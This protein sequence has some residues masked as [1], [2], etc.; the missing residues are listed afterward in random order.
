MQLRRTALGTVI[1]AGLILSLSSCG[2]KD[3]ATQPAPVSDTPAPTVS[4]AST[5]TPKSV[6][7]V[8]AA[9]AHA[10]TDYRNYIA[11]QSRGFVT[12]HPTY[13]YE[14]VMTGNALQAM[15]SFVGGMN[16]AGSKFSGSLTFLK[17]SVVALNLKAKPATATVQACLKDALVLK[18]KRGK[19]MSS[20]PQR[21]STNDRLVLVGKLW[22]VTETTTYDAHS[23]GCT[24]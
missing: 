18:N 6:D 17:G 2:G 1:A 5:P 8:A 15:K 12:N 13:P 3:H 14:Q 10:M 4:A 23:A 19:T 16:L 24:R 11:F 22:K 21:V 20:P 7:P 9:K